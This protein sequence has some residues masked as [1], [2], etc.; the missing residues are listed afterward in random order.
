MH[1]SNQLTG[2]FPMKEQCD[3]GQAKIHVERLMLH[4]DPNCSPAE[5]KQYL[6][7]VIDTLADLDI[8]TEEIHNSLYMEY[9]G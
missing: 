3:L 2:K 1:E 5:H 6:A 8:I 7:G 4:L 9:V